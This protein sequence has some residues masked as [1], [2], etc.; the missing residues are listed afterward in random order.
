M[1][2]NPHFTTPQRSSSVISSVTQNTQ[3]PH[4]LL[5]TSSYNVDVHCTHTTHTRSALA[6]HLTSSLAA[7]LAV[8]ITQC[9]V[10]SGYNNTPTNTQSPHRLLRASSYDVALHHTHTAH[11]VYCQFTSL[12]C[13]RSVADVVEQCIKHT[14][15]MTAGAQHVKLGW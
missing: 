13:C 3:Q 15:G 10:T 6:V 8:V 11:A 7:Q 2:H 4:G 1:N 14:A 5:H 9:N 12:T